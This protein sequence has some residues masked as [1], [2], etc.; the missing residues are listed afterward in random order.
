MTSVAVSTD[1][2]AEWGRVSDGISLYSSSFIT[3]KLYQFYAIYSW[4]QIIVGPLPTMLL[5]YG[6]FSSFL[7]DS[8]TEQA[9][10]IVSD[11]KDVGI[12]AATGGASG[13][14]SSIIRKV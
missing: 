2:T 6:M 12:S 5:G 7:T 3:S 10:Q 4:L 8:Q 1:L 9:P 13:A 11:V 14:A